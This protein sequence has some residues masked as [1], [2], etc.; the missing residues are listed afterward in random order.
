MA[1][2]TAEDVA[3]NI[4]DEKGVH[5]I[6]FTNYSLDRTSASSLGIFQWAF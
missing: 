4:I 2:L 1:L 6:V 5:Y 3:L